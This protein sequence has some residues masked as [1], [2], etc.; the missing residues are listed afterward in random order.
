M[1]LVLKH[2]RVLYNGAVATMPDRTRSRSAATVAPPFGFGF[3]PRKCGAPG[4]RAAA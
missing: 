2:G 4:G 1:A 3:P